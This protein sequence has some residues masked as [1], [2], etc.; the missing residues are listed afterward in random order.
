M[1]SID[2]DITRLSQL[3]SYFHNILTDE[4]LND[5][6]G[7]VNLSIPK[8]L[9]LNPNYNFLYKMYVFLNKKQNEVALDKSYEYFWKRT[10]NLYEI[11]T[12]I[13]TIGALIANGYQPVEGWIFL[14]I[15]MRMYC[16]F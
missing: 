10:D 1:E 9:V 3:I 2:S 11:W 8:A 16:L 12:Y 14:K 15:R 13:K 7:E 5:S 4:F 6:V